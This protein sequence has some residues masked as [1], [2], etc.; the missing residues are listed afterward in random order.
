V[1]AI[2]RNQ[3]SATSLNK[4]IN[5]APAE[6]IHSLT[7]IILKRIEFFWLCPVFKKRGNGIA[8]A[9]GYTG[10][11]IGNAFFSYGLLLRSGLCWPAYR[12]RGEALIV[13]LPVNVNNLGHE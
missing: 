8:L 6:L 1:E 7:N 10:R 12:K 11:R 2:L 5:P 13:L 4:K 9:V 3:F